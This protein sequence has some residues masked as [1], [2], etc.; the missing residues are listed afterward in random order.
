VTYAADAADAAAAAHAAIAAAT[1]TAAAAAAAAA[2]SSTPASPSSSFPQAFPSWFGLVSDSP[3]PGTDIPGLASGAGALSLDHDVAAVEAVAWF[4]GA[5]PADYASAADAAAAA[6]AHSPVS[7]PVFVPPTAAARKIL[8][9]GE[10][11]W[12]DL[13]SAAGWSISPL[14]CST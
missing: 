6:A 1:A 2:A 14:F 5:G 9:K 12:V 4:D 7:A 10:A 11:M 8:P 3:D 13:G